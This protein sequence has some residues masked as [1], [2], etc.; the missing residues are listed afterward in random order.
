VDGSPAALA[1]LVGL[2]TV[3]FVAGVLWLR[4]RKRARARTAAGECA[5]C[6]APFTNGEG[7]PSF[8]GLICRNC[9]VAV[10]HRNSVAALEIKA[11]IVGSYALAIGGG[12]KLYLA[13][14]Q[15]WWVAMVS[16]SGLATLLA[17]ALRF[18]SS[19]SWAPRIDRSGR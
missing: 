10:R 16:M 18:V 4:Q 12:V 8:A 11:L 6:G 2:V 3:P 7:L 5:L 15:G 13:G 1:I 14:D 19:A 9:G 17:L